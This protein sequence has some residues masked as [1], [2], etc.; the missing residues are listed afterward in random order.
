MAEYTAQRAGTRKVVS[1]NPI[2]SGVI[3]LLIP[4]ARPPIDLGTAHH[5]FLYCMPLNIKQ[6]NRDARCG[7]VH[8][9]RQSSV[10]L[11]LAKT[12]K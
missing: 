8:T 4:S 1:P 6:G 9:A 11:H 3:S 12:L 2:V 5:Y 10:K 7:M